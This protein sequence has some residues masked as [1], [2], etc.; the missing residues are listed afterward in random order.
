MF[1]KMRESKGFTLVELMIVVAIIGILAAVAVPYY[2]RYIQKARLTSLVMPGVHS[3]Q[4]NYGSY[5]SLN[6]TFPT[7]AATLAVLAGDANSQ[8][9]SVAV[10]GTALT[11]TVKG[12][13]AGNPLAT[14]DGQILTASAMADATTKTM[15]V[16]WA[17]TG[18]LATAL[19]LVGV[20]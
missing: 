8:Y 20:Q 7:T 12:A 6:N 11:F 14:L 9:F 5:F 13:G 3:L 4:T 1:I 16:G 18:N 2:Q 10:A 15:I 17:Y 19:G